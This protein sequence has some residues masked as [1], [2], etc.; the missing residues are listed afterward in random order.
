[1]LEI[2]PQHSLEY[3]GEILSR[4][5][6][7]IQ[8][9]ESFYVLGAASMGKTRLLDF[10]LKADVQEYYLGQNAKNHW[11][12]RV[13][14]NRLPARDES[15]TFYELLLSSILLDI[16]NH[17]NIMHL[18]DEIARL[19]SEVIQ[20]QDHLRAL[21]FFELAINKLCQV[22]EM[23]LCFLFDEFDEAY[24]TL[25]AEIF[26]Q[27]R[28]VRDANK[29]RLSFALFLRQLPEILRPPDENESFYELL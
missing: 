20:N 5:F 18:R 1:M 9:T 3:R 19:D 23:K 6:R 14:L 26:R 12:I 15:W 4:F 11:L 2:G 22:Y 7:H 16:H 28:G 13:D 17:E 21:R 29:N 24:K 8:S 27:L 25:P 10:L